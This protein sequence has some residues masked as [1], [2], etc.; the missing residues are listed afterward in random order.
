MS[1]EF[2]MQFIPGGDEGP[3]T[4]RMSPETYAEINRRP[5][6]GSVATQFGSGANR[7]LAAMLGLPVD[8]LTA[9]MN[10]ALP[11]SME[12]QNP[13]GGSQSFDRLLSPFTTDQ[14]PQNAP[15]RYAASIGQDIGASVIPGGVAM[16]GAQAP[17]R[18]L[19]LEGASSVGSGVGAQAAE[20]MGAGPVGTMVGGLLG[21]LLPIGIAR[22][23]RP[24]PQAPTLQDLRDEAEGIYA[25]RDAVQQGLDP[26][27]RHGLLAEM[28][29]VGRPNTPLAA[30]NVPRT[31]RFLDS[32]DDLPGAPRPQDLHDFRRV[33]QNDIMGSNPTLSPP[34]T[35]SAQM[36]TEA[37]DEYLRRI[38][39]DPATDPNLARGIQDTFEAGEL[40]RR[41]EALETL[42]GETGLLTRASR[43][44]A[45]SGTGGN[46]L[47]AVRQ[48][49]RR[50]LDND[51]L[52]AGYTAEE[53]Q[54]MED[55]V[56]GTRLENFL[57][58]VGR[59]SPTT[60]GLQLLTN[61]GAVGGAAALGSPSSTAMA[62]A[63]F[64]TGYVSQ[65]AAE[66]MANRHTR[67]LL[68][69]IANGGPLPGRGIDDAELR[70]LIA[71][72][73][74]ETPGLLSVSE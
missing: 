17:M 15:E 7:G 74:A 2:I 33:M 39:D 61:I 6:V 41:S 34:E 28:E 62:M 49:I 25:R 55:I 20:D 53:L 46:V 44:A 66:H 11:E 26:Q 9:A 22:R 52:R 48:N 71:A 24:A 67:T 56:S 73:A 19:A 72:M 21:G 54:I 43:R 40:Y 29:S 3:V 5:T 31:N 47:N 23:A 37:F 1:D 36:M 32:M 70:A 45:T 68:D 13:V 65:Q 59:L 51:N 50:I 16:R 35:R 64:A 10:A 42:T 14:E 63:P 57:R 60:G 69:T 58:R 38:A 30:R 8:A 18:F 12:I 27:Q 4:A